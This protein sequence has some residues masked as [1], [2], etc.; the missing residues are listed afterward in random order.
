MKRKVLLWLKR[1]EKPAATI[2]VVL[3]LLTAL[4]TGAYY[5]GF[6]RAQYE[7]SKIISDMQNRQI[8]MCDNYNQT[9]FE[10]RT[11]L[12]EQKEEIILLKQSQDETK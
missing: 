12:L 5:I 4:T 3:T 1:I 6:S 2:G 8:E 7:A 11:Q 9:I 10:L